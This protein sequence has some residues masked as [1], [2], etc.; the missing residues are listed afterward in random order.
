MADKTK[1]LLFGGAIYALLYA[2]YFT[3]ALLFSNTVIEQI[4]YIFS[5][6]ITPIIF[7]AYC[8]YI[9]FSKFEA[10]RELKVSKLFIALGFITFVL[11][12]YN[13]F[14]ISVTLEAFTFNSIISVAFTVFVMAYIIK[15]R[16]KRIYTTLYLSCFLLF[17]LSGFLIIDKQSFLENSALDICSDI[18]VCAEGLILK[19]ENGKDWVVNNDNCIKEGR[20]S[21]T[22]KECIMKWSDNY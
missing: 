6:Y 16:Q 17:I 7:I 18:G 1:W 21:D 11:F 14:Y 5:D 19:D 3:T 13:L 12:L 20:W 2:A 4:I 8:F 10:K 9:L 15:L 22:K